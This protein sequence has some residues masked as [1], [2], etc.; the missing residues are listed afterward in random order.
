MLRKPLAEIS[1]EA[2]ALATRLARALDG[3]EALSL[4]DASRLGSG[5]LPEKNIPTRVV[6]LRHKTL[7]AEEL[8]LRLR[9]HKPPIFTRIQDDRV[10]IDP[11]TL[12]AGDAEE[13]E[14]AV[15]GMRNAE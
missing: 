1:A 7:S 13:I 4:D 15:N 12:Q 9:A 11:R 10:L 8:A 14:R 3:L 6:S 2:A 5:S